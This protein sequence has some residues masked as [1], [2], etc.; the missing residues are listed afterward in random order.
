[1]RPIEKK[2]CNSHGWQQEPMGKKLALEFFVKITCAT[3]TV[4]LFP[5]LLYF[6]Y[7]LIIIMEPL[8]KG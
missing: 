8:A 7:S 3:P 5:Q 2:A 6:L 1:M 4:S